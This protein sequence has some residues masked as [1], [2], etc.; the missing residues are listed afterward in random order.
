MGAGKGKSRVGAAIAH[1]F[2]KH[3]AMP[4][5]L[6]FSDKGLL[7]RDK[8]QCQDLWYFTGAVY[9]GSSGRLHHVVGVDSLPPKKKCVVIIDESDDVMMKDLE[10][11]VKKT[12]GQ[13]LQIICL[14][15]TPD[16]GL[17][18]GLERNLMIS[19]GYHMIKT[20]ETHEL[21]LPNVQ[22]FVPLNS[23]EEVMS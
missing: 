20:Q 10:N 11:F 14:T 19:M 6:V 2:L 22:E 18:D 7:E 13:N 3:T 21:N 23:K 4:V 5:Y 1:H 9:E 12:M 15:A 16:D 8:K 17:E